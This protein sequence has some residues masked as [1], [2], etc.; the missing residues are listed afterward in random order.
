[1]P[2]NEFADSAGVVHPVSPSNVLPVDQT[3]RPYDIQIG[4]YQRVAPTGAAVVDQTMRLIGGGFQD[5]QL[6]T[7]AWTGN[8]S[9]TGSSVAV[10]NGINTLTSG[11]ANSGYA[12]VQSATKARFLFASTNVFRGTFRLPT[13]GGTN[14]TR[15]WGAFNFGTLPAVQDGFFFSYNGT[16]KTLSVNCCNA[17]V[18]TSVS[19]GS[20]NGD[21][22]SY[23]L[24][25]NQ[26]NYEIVYQ[27]PG[28]FF[29]I[30]G[31][32]IHH[33]VSGSALLSS[34]MHLAV[35]A[36]ASNSAS[37]TISTSLEA[38]A[39]SIIRYGSA[40]PAP[41]FLNIA[42]LGTTTIKA[43]P[44]QLHRVTINTAGSNTNT[45]TLYDSLTGSGTKI[46]TIGDAAGAIVTLE[47]N[48]DFMN[49][50]TAVSATGTSSDITVIYD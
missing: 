44:G 7:V 41:Q 29:F 5:S 49:G 20:F 1:M 46:A 45:I 30:D 16:S 15:G 47:Y 2:L 38:W 50:L 48:L 25:T 27:V 40:P 8:N 10:S 14:T 22:K 42:A 24:D 23:T 32:L 31:A 33:F 13:L 4:K 21:V 18:T 6:D 26:H 36:F 3:S 39:G 9:G 17:G 37:G 28:A 19:S 34:I 43:G 35:S 11:T 12:T